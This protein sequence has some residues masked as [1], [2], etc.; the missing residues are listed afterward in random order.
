LGGGG[1]GGG[2]GGGFGGGL[3][4]GLAASSATAAVTCVKNLNLKSGKPSH[5][6]WQ[7]GWCGWLFDM[8]LRAGVAPRGG[9]L[10]ANEWRR[11]AAGERF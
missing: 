2:L 7:A 9:A 4:G 5:P 1:I 10:R 11:N 3:G 8:L 6:R